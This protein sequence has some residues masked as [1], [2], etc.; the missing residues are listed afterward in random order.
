M[1]EEYVPGWSII[2]KPLI[3]TVQI[4]S[5]EK[6]QSYAGK[7]A[8]TTSM[9]LTDLGMGD[10][11]IS[12]ANGELNVDINRGIYRLAKKLGFKRATIEV[13]EGTKATRMGTFV[14]N[15]DGLDRYTV[16]IV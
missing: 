15:R 3:S 8:Y 2:Y 11:R 12:L 5:D 4:Y 9:L 14:C 16:D 13:P 1:I 10:C 6:G 7:T